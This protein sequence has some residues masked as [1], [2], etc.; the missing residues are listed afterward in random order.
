MPPEPSARTLTTAQIELIGR[1]IDEGARY[2]RHWAFL[3]PRRPQVPKV[4]NKSWPRN[5]IDYFVLGRLEAEG[6]SP[7]GEADKATLLRRAAFDLI[8]LPPT[9]E[10]VDSFLEDSSP[11]AYEKRVDQLLASPHY[12][13]RMARVWLDL[14]RYADT[15]GYNADNLR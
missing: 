5:A 1:W 12:G 8:G 11:D 4:K 6:L 15:N 14:A 7:S 2:S 9:P 3:P 13:E 10:E